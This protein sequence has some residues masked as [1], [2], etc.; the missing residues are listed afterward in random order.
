LVTYVHPDSPAGKAGITAGSVLLRLRVPGQPL[1]VEVL[2]EEDQMRAGPFPWDRLDQIG[3]QFFDRI[4]TPWPPAESTFTRAL[5]DLGFGTRFTAEFFVDGKAS[6]HEFEVV[7]G[8]THYESAPR[9][10]SESLGLTVRAMTYDVRR[11]MQRPATDPGVVV[12]KVEPGGKASVAGVKPYE[13]IT[14]INDQPVNSVA[15]FESLAAKGG[16]LKLSIKRMAK[17]RIVTVKA[18]NP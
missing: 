13:L 8:P 14:H 15:D 17:G 2:L 1:A 4:P 18:G 3:E 12:G 5:T 10:K 16:E 7:S 9:F 11:Y 6:S